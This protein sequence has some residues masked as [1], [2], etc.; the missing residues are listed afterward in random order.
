[1]STRPFRFV[2][3]GDFHLEQ[4]LAGVA[5]VPDHLR[6]LFLDAPY[7]AAKNVFDAALAEDADFVVLSG[8]LLH[9]SHTGPRGPLFLIEQFQRLA[10]RGIDVYWAGGT[11]D[12]PEAWPA[13]LALPQNVHVFPQGH[14]E[15]VTVLHDE[16][17]MARVVGIS[18]DRQRP[19]RPSDF[20]PDPSFYSIAILNGDA[21]LSAMQ[22]RGFQYW[23]I[24]GRQDRGTP[25][26]GPQMIHHCGSPQGRRPE[27][28]GPHGCTLVEV[29]A[30]RQTRTSLITTDIVRWYAE[31]LVVEES[32][33]QEDLETRLRE[34]IQSLLEAGPRFSP[35]PLGEGSGV[36][37]VSSGQIINPPS[38]L[39]LPPSSNPQSLIPNPS[40]HPNP[41]PNGEGTGLLI[42]WT[43][44]GRG[45]IITQLR[46]TRLAA[47]LLQRLRDEYGHRSP[48]AWSVSLEVELSETLPPEW[49]E[50]ETI[51]GDF[52]RA[53]RQ[54]QMN[55]DESPTLEA[56]MAEAHLAGALG[57]ATT[58]SNKTARDRVLREAA[59]LGVDLL[60]GEESQA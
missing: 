28:C 32:T 14:V 51:R 20:S 9:P 50:Q 8:D 19:A 57:A 15:D 26:S 6:D 58:F 1:M 46:R 18:R 56:Y 30:Q 48:A 23:A 21:V 27:H 31:R 39:R 25:L 4:P 34:H 54:L 36:R 44:A 42:S 17:P 41:L 2:H 16:D 53:V 33:S 60:S 55:P 43:I 10:E 52:L 37:A 3:A 7:A 24:G 38:A 12:P 22:A 5:E 45:P 47:E 11:V 35:L 49:Y 29:D 40:P 59:V 13:E